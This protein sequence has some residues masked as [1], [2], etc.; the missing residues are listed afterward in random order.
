MRAC[1]L[2]CSLCSDGCGD[3]RTLLRKFISA[4]Q[5]RGV[6]PD[7]S[8][9]HGRNWKEQRQFDAV[10]SVDVAIKPKGFIYNPV[11]SVHHDRKCPPT[12]VRLLLRADDVHEHGSARRRC[13]CVCLLPPHA[14]ARLTWTSAAMLNCLPA[15]RG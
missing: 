8:A 15:G 9:A 7:L 4:G 11:E 5:P 3:A 6:S 1:G 12:M 10:N 14:R 2:F 13:M